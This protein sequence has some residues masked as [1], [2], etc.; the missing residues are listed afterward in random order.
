VEFIIDF[1][2][3]IVK[4]G[5]LMLGM[6]IAQNGY[7]VTHPPGPL[8]K[9]FSSNNRR[10]EATTRYRR[11]RRARLALLPVYFVTQIINAEQKSC[12]PETNPLEFCQLTTYGRPKAPTTQLRHPN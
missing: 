2:M 10:V 8:Y 5:Q 4:E 3:V 9:Y 12:S 6:R 7:H 11:S 1:L